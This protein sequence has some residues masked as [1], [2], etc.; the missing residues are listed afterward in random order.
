[1]KENKWQ[2]ILGNKKS[3]TPVKIMRWTARLWSL[4]AFALALIVAIGPDPNA[5]R[6]PSLREV[7]LLS[8][9]LIAILGL[10]MA[11]KWERFG[12]LLAM[13]IMPVREIFYILVYREWLINFLLIWALV[14]PPAMMYYFADV[15]DRKQTS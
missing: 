6:P 5:V 7:F 4:F 12:A 11:W 13:I 3:T 10:M 2:W 8:L 1:M 15:M 14:I 9:W